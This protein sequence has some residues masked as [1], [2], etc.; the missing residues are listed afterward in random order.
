MGESLTQRLA[1][2]NKD[3]TIV[4]FLQECHDKGFDL[5]PDDISHV[6][7][8]DFDYVRHQNIAR[9]VRELS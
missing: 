1:K 9:I 6:L 5:D 8:L 7:Q 2:A 4:D 3:K